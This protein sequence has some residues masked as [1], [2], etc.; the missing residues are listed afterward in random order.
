[1]AALIVA[2]ACH[3]SM[4]PHAAPCQPMQPHAG[5]TL[6]PNGGMGKATLLQ[7]AL[8]ALQLLQGQGGGLSH[9]AM[10]TAQQLALSVLL[11]SSAP[12]TPPLPGTPMHS[13][14]GALEIPDA[15]DMAVAWQLLMLAVGPSLT[16]GQLVSATAREEND[17]NSLS[18]SSSPGSGGWGGSSPT[19]AGGSAVASLQLA[20]VD[21]AT[22]L[23][24][25]RCLDLALE[26]M[27]THVGALLGLPSW[28]NQAASIGLDGWQVGQGQS[29]AGAGG[30]Q[31]GHGWIGQ[32]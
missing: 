14:F 27:A 4:Q 29:L 19:A 18:N 22:W 23:R 15:D 1:M 7:A 31:P 3:P 21:R 8:G 2:S 32:G 25:Q 13:A 5:S 6:V 10:E 30:G 28:L 17:S 9:E 11:P 24:D 26:V 20:V 16:I 12:P